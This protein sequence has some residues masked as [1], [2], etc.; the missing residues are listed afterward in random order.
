MTK[1]DQL[2]SSSYLDLVKE[3]PLAPITCETEKVAAENLISILYEI[4][5]EHQVLTEEQDK[6]LATLNI[7]LEE[8]R[9]RNK[10]PLI[11]DIYGVDLLKVLIKENRL[12]QK[13]LV[14]IFK[15]ESILSEI[16]HGKKGRKLTLE[17]IEKLAEYFKIPSSAFLSR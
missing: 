6:Y 9:S 2:K 12:R 10:K 4:E 15:T 11:P 17:H 5:E 16:L 14:S 8:Y 7:L 13:D 3:L 1:I